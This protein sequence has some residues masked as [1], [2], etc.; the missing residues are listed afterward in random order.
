M[1]CNCAE[2]RVFKLEG[3]L[4]AHLSSP[5]ILIWKMRKQ[6]PQE[7]KWLAQRYEALLQWSGRTG[8]RETPGLCT[9]NP[10]FP[11]YCPSFWQIEKSGNLFLDCE[12]TAYSIY[13]PKQVLLLPPWVDWPKSVIF[14]VCALL[15]IQ[16]LILLSLPSD[17]NLKLGKHLINLLHWGM[18][19]KDYSIF[20]PRH[21]YTFKWRGQLGN[22]RN[23]SEMLGEEGQYFGDQE[24]LSSSYHSTTLLLHKP[25]H[26]CKF[27]ILLTQ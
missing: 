12:R 21:I 16:C 23:N 17:Q 5:A 13:N 24:G 6:K 15:C 7:L 10:I 9:Q 2:A 19:V 4:R 25:G 18:I 14:M 26:T 20:S 8:L 27:W 11:L 3:I 22:W 1:V